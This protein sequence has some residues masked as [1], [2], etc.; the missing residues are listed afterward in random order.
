MKKQ[1]IDNLI[2]SLYIKGYFSEYLPEEFST[3]D[4]IKLKNVS[5]L[6]TDIKPYS[7]TMNKNDKSLERRTISIPEIGSYINVI[8]YLE[9][10][11]ILDYFMKL[12]EKSDNSLS[13]ILTKSGMVRTFSNPYRESQETH[14]DDEEN[15]IDNTISK[16][17]KAVGS[18]GILKL[19]IANFYG[20]FYTHNIACVGNGSEWAENQYRLKD[21]KKISKRYRDLAKLDNLVGRLNQKRTHGLLIG[22][23][24]SYIIAEGLMCTI[25]SELI[26]E[27]N[28]TMDKSINF[29]RFIDDYDVFVKSEEDIPLI[30]LTFTRV[31]EKY[32][33]VLSDSKTEYIKFPYYIYE[34]FED[35]IEINQD[36]PTSKNLL[37]VYSKLANFELTEKQKGGLFYFASNLE[38]ITSK[39]NF[40]DALSLILSVIKNN[41][42]SIPV[43]CKTIL[44]ICRVYKSDVKLD[45]IFDDLYYFL[46]KCINSQYEWEQIWIIY[47]LIKIDSVKVNQRLLSIIDGGLSEL[48]LIMI[49]NEFDANEL[50][51]DLFI[52]IAENSSWLLRYELYRLNIVNNDFLNKYLVDIK[53]ISNFKILKSVDCQLYKTINKEIDELPF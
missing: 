24:I 45:M 4:F 49:L 2:K 5:L 44:S 38:K 10:N 51:A 9:E 12:S 41:A 36:P 20:S 26:K 25:D 16:L 11:E 53:A 7:Y 15:F 19:D 39:L 34:N 35:I 22:P 48:A 14:E 42:K 28:E 18:I 1:A 23:M 52:K 33:F 32:G 37:N 6:S 30:I 40:E 13:K 50:D 47:T 27:L 3:K 43:A 21:E 46:K 29:V 8:K 31:L 17:R